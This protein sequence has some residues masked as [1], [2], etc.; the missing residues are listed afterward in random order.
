M[1]TRL[2]NQTAYQNRFQ[3]SSTMKPL[4]R[5]KE[6][7]RGGERRGEE[8]R[9]EERRNGKRSGGETRW[10]ENGCGEEWE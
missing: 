5:K 4:S 6:E 9:S 8:R 3:Q 10:G 2:Q 7:C 1:K